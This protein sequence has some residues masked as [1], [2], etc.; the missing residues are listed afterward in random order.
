MKLK[1]A[2]QSDWNTENECVAALVPFAAYIPENLLH[3]Y[4]RCLVMT[5]V[6]YIGNSSS[7]SRTDF[8]ANGAAMHIP[9]M[10]QAFD[11]N[12]ASAFIESIKGNTVLRKRIVTPVKLQRLRSLGRIVLEKVSDSFPD[13]ELLEALVNPEEEDKFLKLLDK[14]PKH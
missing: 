11:D 9:K 7:W 2:E 13:K 12:A 10:L 4:V 6:G 1:S 8:Y 14:Q 5:Y 3:D